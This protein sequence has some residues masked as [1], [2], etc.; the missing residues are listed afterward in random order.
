MAR[1]HLREGEE[2]LTRQASIVAE[3]EIEGHTE[4]AAF[5]KRLLENMRLALELQK[6]HLRDIEAQSRR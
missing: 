2:R 4:Q 1:R 3:L 5:G 6:R